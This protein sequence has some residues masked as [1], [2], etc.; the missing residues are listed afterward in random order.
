MENRLIRRKTANS[1]KNVSLVPASTAKQLFSTNKAVFPKT[2]LWTLNLDQFKK[3]K[4]LKIR[5][6]Q[7]CVMELNATNQ[8]S[9]ANFHSANY[10]AGTET[11]MLTVKFQN[12]KA[13]LFHFISSDNT[14]Q[15]E[16]IKLFACEALKWIA[17]F[18]VILAHHTWLLIL[19]IL[20]FLR[21]KVQLLFCQGEMGGFSDKVFLRQ[22]PM[23]E[24]ACK[25]IGRTRS[26]LCPGKVLKTDS[27]K[28][29]RFHIWYPT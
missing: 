15:R 1:W 6:Q 22:N 4:K 17:F 10:G 9:E 29:S 8:T 11:D 18:L 14:N 26:F 28:C 20:A 5:S 7:H 3:I 16:S 21:S 23:P 2:T 24:Q 12:L 13:V 27:L 19:G 25:C